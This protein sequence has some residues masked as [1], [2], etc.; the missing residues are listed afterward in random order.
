[1]SEVP[2]P[3]DSEGLGSGPL[4]A[5]LSVSV[6]ELPRPQ[7]RLLSGT[8]LNLVARVLVAERVAHHLR[9]AGLTVGRFLPLPTQRSVLRTPQGPECQRHTA[10]GP[11]RCTRVKF[12]SDGAAAERAGDRQGGAEPTKMSMTR[13]GMDRHGSSRCRWETSRQGSYSDTLHPCFYGARRYFRGFPVTA[14]PPLRSS[15]VCRLLGW[16]APNMHPFHGAPHSG[17]APFSEV[18]RRIHRSGNCLRERREVRHRSIPRVAI[19]QTDRRFRPRSGGRSVA[20]AWAK[21]QRFDRRRPTP[22][23]LAFGR[24]D[25]ALGWA[26]PETGSRTASPS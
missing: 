3:H 13:Q 20:T 6:E 24:P 10:F 22:E 19:H 5:P 26:P 23:S 8:C 2:G 17:H 18:P 9:G 11:R 21:T 4:P 25:L 14:A 7:D 12:D 1:M 16:I 15:P